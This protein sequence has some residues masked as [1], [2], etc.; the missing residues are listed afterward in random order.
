LFT[1]GGE[2]IKKIIPILVIGIF[3]LSGLGAVSGTE[4]DEENVIS[5][6]VFFSQP[7]ICEKEDYISLELEESTCDSWEEDKPTLPVVTKVYTFPFGTIIDNVAVTFSD[8]TEKQLSKPIEPSPERYILSIDV[9]QNIDKSDEVMTYSDIEI[10][11]EERFGYRTGAGL[12]GEEMAV[13]LT[14]SIYPDQYYP[15]HNIVSHAGKAEIKIDYTL[16]ETP[17]TFPDEYDLLIIGPESFES[18]LQPLVDH[19]NNLNPP[20]K[21]I[22]VNLED[23]PSGVGVDQQED[24]KY[25]IRDAK[26]NWG[27]T[28]LLL[29]GAGKEGEEIFPVRHAWVQ[30]EGHEDYFPSDLYYADFYNSTMGFPNW[31]ADGDGKYAEYSVDMK[32]IDVIPDVY[33]GK[34]PAN[35][36]AEVTDVVNKIIDYKAHNKMTNKILQMGGDSFT[37]DNIYEG[38]YANTKVLE[39][40]PGYTTTRL[41]GSHPNPDYDTKEF[42]KKNI[43]KGFMSAV[44]FVDFCGH[45]SWASIATHPPQDKSVW[46]PPATLR[47]QRHGW[48][49]VDFDLYFVNNAKKL[50]LCVYKSCSNNKYSVGPNCF[51]WRTV[52]RPN[53]GGIAAIAAAG[54]SYG[55]TG[56]AIVESCT[57]WMEVH[58]FEEFGMENTK[59][60]GQLWGNCVT[61]YYNNFDPNFDLPD[62]KTMLE[63]SFFGDPTVVLEDGDNPK[64]AEVDVPVFLGL[65]ERILERYP[66]LV[67]FLKE[68][69][70]KLLGL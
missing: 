2:N 56:T 30:S 22:L 26:E 52:S 67:Q 32:N 45:G 18:A 6:N 11:P 3:V 23:I 51:G 49:Y 33:L 37:D 66:M 27:I 58:T 46:I 31:D 12:K 63:W 61:D 4:S 41:W 19:K 7:T 53:G 65:L 35:N 47:S 60:L 13:Y 21:T 28:Y 17:V 10:Y 34:L 68:I 44:D 69:L 16:P 9:S 20:V 29:V 70:D 1:K 38:E 25:Y 5:E 43:R 48:T 57:G 14:I 62:W 40:L 24:I 64:C 59:I 42:T 36:A 15:Q 39:K 54:I 55:A 50:P 8:F